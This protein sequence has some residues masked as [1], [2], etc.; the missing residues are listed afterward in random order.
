MFKG[1]YIGINDIHGKKIKEGDF[2]RLPEENSIV[3]KVAYDAP[4][5]GLFD[6]HDNPKVDKPVHKNV[7]YFKEREVIVKEYR[8]TQE[9]TTITF[10]KEHPEMKIVIKKREE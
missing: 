8:Y 2:M 1:Y 10:D 9:T 5:F 4:S 7:E 3:Y 6:I